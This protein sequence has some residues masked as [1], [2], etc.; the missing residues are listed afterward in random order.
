MTG[1]AQKAANK[2]G[3]GAAQSAAAGQAAR[4]AALGGG[5]FDPE[6]LLA[7]E[8]FDGFDGGELGELHMVLERSVPGCGWRAGKS[9]TH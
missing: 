2:A 4:L 6:V 3:T 7:L 9:N 5:D 8:G 1:K